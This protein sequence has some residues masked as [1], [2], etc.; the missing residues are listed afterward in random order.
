[1]KIL[2][3]IIFHDNDLTFRACNSFL[4]DSLNRTSRIL[5]IINVDQLK[6]QGTQKLSPSWLLSKSIKSC[7]IRNRYLVH[8]NCPFLLMKR[9]SRVTKDLF[10]A[11]L[12]KWTSKRHS[13]LFKLFQ[14]QQL[15]WMRA[16]LLKISHSLNSRYDSWQ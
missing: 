16:S 5:V 6:Q 15:R 9:K 4:N 8:S 13:K 14:V 11:S 1:M 12:S 10:K 3:N 7:S 2:S